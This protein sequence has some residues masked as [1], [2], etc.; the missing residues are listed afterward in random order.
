MADLKE[1]RK[2][3]DSVNR[4]TKDLRSRLK[5]AEEKNGSL[6][7]ANAK[8]NKEIEENR[9]FVSKLRAL[10]A[11]NNKLTEDLKYWEKKHYDCHHE[12]ATL[13]EQYELLDNRKQE[14]ALQTQSD[15]QTHQ[16]MELKV[17]EF[18]DKFVEI[19]DKYRRLL[20]T[21]KFWVS[22]LINLNAIR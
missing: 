12:L 15:A 10:K 1:W 21:K 7:T 16:N 8:L 9:A 19:N 5:Q 4:A 18:K 20:E 3:R 11:R 6:K 13:K 17:Q 22:L 14:L 2:N